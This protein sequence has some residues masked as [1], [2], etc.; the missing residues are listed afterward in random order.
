MKKINHVYLLFLGPFGT[1]KIALKMGRKKAET[2]V[3]CRPT[4]PLGSWYSEDD[5]GGP[6]SGGGQR[7]YLRIRVFSQRVI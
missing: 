7:P 4:I 3:G 2:F 1:A 5:P 6:D